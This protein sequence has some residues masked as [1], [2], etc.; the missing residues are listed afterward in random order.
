MYNQIA[1]VY[2]LIC[3]INWII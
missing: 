2:D 3:E 1:F